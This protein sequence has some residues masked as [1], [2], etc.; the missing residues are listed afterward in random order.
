MA[1]EY[2]I[3]QIALGAEDVEMAL[4]HTIRDDWEFLSCVALSPTVLCYTFQREKLPARGGRKRIEDTSPVSSPEFDKLSVEEQ[5]KA[6]D[7]EFRNICKEVSSNKT[8]TSVGAD[9]VTAAVVASKVVS[10][11]KAKKILSRSEKVEHKPIKKVPEPE[12]KVVASE[13]SN[14]RISPRT[15]KPMRVYKKRIK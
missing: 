9:E 5:E 4:N 11:R 14:V 3:L 10:T 2:K 15:G 1:R 8:S 7:S 13:Q 12:Q 6:L